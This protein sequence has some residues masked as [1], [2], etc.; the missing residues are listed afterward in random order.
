M[1]AAR[2]GSDRHPRAG[3]LPS[4]AVTDLPDRIYHLAAADEWDA[5]QAAGDYRRST[6]DRSL[7]QEGFIHCSTAAQVRGTADAFY[8]GRADVVLL[9]IDPGRIS[10]PIKVEVPADRT[11]GFPHIYGPIDLDAVVSATPLA[12]GPDDTLALPDLR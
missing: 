11:D 7:E 2:A 10:S 12:L 9:T 4:G 6:A 1:L 3:P 8:R 5:A